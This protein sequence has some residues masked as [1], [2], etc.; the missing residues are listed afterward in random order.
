MNTLSLVLNKRLSKSKKFI[1][2]SGQSSRMCTI[3]TQERIPRGTASQNELAERGEPRT[4]TARVG[5]AGQD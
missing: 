5:S 1:I 3:E 2:Q 4:G